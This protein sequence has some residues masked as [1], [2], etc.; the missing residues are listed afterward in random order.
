M[1]INL[2]LIF[3]SSLIISMALIPI[4]IRSAAYLGVL[5]LPGERKMHA[6]PVARVGGIAFASGA[7]ASILLWTRIDPLLLSYLIGAS[8]ILCFGVLDDRINLDPKD[9]FLAQLLAALIVV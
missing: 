9:K 6:A 5:D 4:L 8:V 1:M 2:F 7:L 3:I